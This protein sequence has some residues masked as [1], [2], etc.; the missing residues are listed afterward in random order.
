MTALCLRHRWQLL[1]IL[2]AVSA[3]PSI[4]LLWLGDASF[5]GYGLAD[6]TENVQIAELLKGERLQPPAP[7]PPL[8]FAAPE[9]AEALPL[10][11]QASRNWSRLDPAFTQK[12]LVVFRIMRDRHGY[13]MALLEGYRSP[14]RQQML[15]SMGSHVTKAGAFQSY[16]QFGLAADC[17]FVRN[18]KLVISEKDP[19]AML[20]YQL[21][22]AVAE[23]VGLI[24]GGRWS[25]RDYGHAELRDQGRR[26]K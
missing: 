26:N 12:L 19:W 13:E 5:T 17:A 4:A 21:Y 23:E 14:E 24:W 9:V 10:P 7:L 25:M 11:M 18:G 20:G 2:F 22:G 1:L 8:L 16:H 6:R 15:S 3:P